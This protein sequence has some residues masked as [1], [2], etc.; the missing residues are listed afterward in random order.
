MGK[1][2]LDRVRRIAL[3][4]PEVTERLSHGAPCFYIQNKRALC[5][6]H[7]HHR[8]DDRISLWC[9]VEPSVQEALVADRPKLFFKP[10]PSAG[11]IFADWIGAYLDTQDVDW[12]LVATVVEQAFVKVAPSKLVAEF[13][14]SLGR[15]RL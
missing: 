13:E 14:I 1:R 11:G 8:G 3:A 6:Y 5:R 2:E 9:P 12:K 10:T 4:L 7:D 15:T